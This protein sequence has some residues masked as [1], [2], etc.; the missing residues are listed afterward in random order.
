MRLAVVGYS[1][2]T[3][4]VIWMYNGVTLRWVGY[5]R[6]EKTVLP[7]FFLIEMVYSSF[8]FVTGFKI[9]SVLTSLAPETGRPFIVAVMAAGLILFVA[10][11]AGLL[12][13]SQNKTLLAAAALIVVTLANLLF[14]FMGVA[15]FFDEEIVDSTLGDNWHS[16]Q[17]ILGD[18]VTPAAYVH[19][20]RLNFKFA[21]LCYL[22]FFLVS[23]P[24]TVSSA[25]YLHR[26][27][28]E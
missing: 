25:V 11:L 28:K 1:C 16:V 23:V 14:L 2:M 3:I 10:G 13:H 8:M 26:K 19:W 12:A 5:S 20:G 4:L 24:L 18:S 9:F 7:C 22:S 15:A 27:L 17:R 21:G 6:L